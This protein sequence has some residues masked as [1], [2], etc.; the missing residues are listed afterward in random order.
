MLMRSV[1]YGAM[2]GKTLD[3]VIRFYVTLYANQ[4]K[5]DK[6][7]NEKTLL[8]SLKEYVEV[9]IFRDTEENEWRSAQV[10]EGLW[11]KIKLMKDIMDI[12]HEGIKTKKQ[13]EAVKKMV[14]RLDL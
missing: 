4:D 2:D 1:V 6:E 5:E 9:K 14:L 12:G 7:E 8:A 13:W 3:T 11:D 10:A